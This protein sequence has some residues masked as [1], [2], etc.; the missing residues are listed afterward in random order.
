AFSVE[1]GHNALSGLKLFV[2]VMFCF[3]CGAT[4]VPAAE[5]KIKLKNGTELHGALTPLESMM[6]GKKTKKADPDAI[7]YFPIVMVTNPLK[8]FFIPVKQQAE[9]DKEVLISGHESF[10]LPQKKMQGG[11]QEI[12]SVQG[13]VGKPEPFNSAGRRTVRLQM[14]K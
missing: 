9:V 13:Y 4:P 3:V 6:A 5:M 12:M 7:A 8:R 14:E 2:A 1:I 11:S 10:T